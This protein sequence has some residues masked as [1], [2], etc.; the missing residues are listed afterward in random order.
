MYPMSIITPGMGINFTCVSYVDQV[1]IGVAIEPH[2]VPEPWP[3]VDGMQRALDQYLALAR[4][5][6]RPRRA[7]RKKA[8]TRTRATAHKKTAAARK[9]PTRTRKASGK[10]KSA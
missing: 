4:K 7:A 1:D 10:A 5:S 6:A 9:A 8:T 3:I 2:L